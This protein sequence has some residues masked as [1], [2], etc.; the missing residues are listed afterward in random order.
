[1]NKIIYTSEQSNI[2]IGQVVLKVFKKRLAVDMVNR[3][4]QTL[5]IAR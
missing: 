1:M 3:S 4:R 2:K 5:K